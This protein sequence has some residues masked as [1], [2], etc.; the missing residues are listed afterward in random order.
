MPVALLRPQTVHKLVVLLRP[1]TVHKQTAF[2]AQA[3]HEGTMTRVWADQVRI[4]LSLN[5]TACR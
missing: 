4:A 5:D 3:V 1:Q 2:L